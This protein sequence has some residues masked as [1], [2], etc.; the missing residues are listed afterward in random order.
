MP[1]TVVPLRPDDVLE[2]YRRGLFPMADPRDGHIDWFSPDP[3]G[4]IPLE[5]AHVPRRLRRYMKSFT[6]TVDR[7]FA[8]QVVGRSLPGQ[9]PRLDEGLLQAGVGSSIM[10]SELES[11][12]RIDSERSE[13][14]HVPVD[15]E[16]GTAKI[17]P[18]PYM[19][20]AAE[21]ARAEAVNWIDNRV[22][23][24]WPSRT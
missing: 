19:Q 24:T 2:A 23:Q 12:V 11:A 17:E 5:A 3:R 7:D 21:R 20:P 6:F 1:S 9:P 8:G 15:L 14:E 16:F 22:M 18:R 4:I 10:Y 13:N